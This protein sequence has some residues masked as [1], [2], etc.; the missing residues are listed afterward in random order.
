MRVLLLLR[1]SPGCGKTTWIQ[2]NGLTN[3]A[4]SADDIRMMCTAPAMFPDGSVKIAMDSDKFVWDMLF[5]VVENRMRRGDFTVIDATNSKTAEMNRYKK[6]C[7]DYRYRIYCVDFTSVPIEIAKQQNAQRPA[8]KV[9][10]EAAIDKMYSR[11]ETQKIPAGITV[12]QPNELNKVWRR[13]LDMSGYKKNP[14]H[15]RCAW[16]LYGAAFLF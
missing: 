2:Q 9:V 5:K 8:Y 3:Y 7:Q 4:V 13:K 16:M 15:W 10:P 14:C 11:F 1:G 12:L 6:L